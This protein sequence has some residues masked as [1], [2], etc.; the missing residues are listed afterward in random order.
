MIHILRINDFINESY[1][2]KD[3]Y[4]ELPKKVRK[5][6]KQPWDSEEVVKKAKEEYKEYVKTAQKIN[7]DNLEILVAK[8]KEAITNAKGNKAFKLR[9]EDCKFAS[10]YFKDGEYDFFDDVDTAV[11]MVRLSLEP[12][13][14]SSK[15]FKR[16]R[17]N[18]FNNEYPKLGSW[19]EKSAYA[20]N[21]YSYL[22]TIADAYNVDMPRFDEDL[23]LL[24]TKSVEHRIDDWNQ[25]RYSRP[26]RK[27][28]DEAYLKMVKKLEAGYE[29][30]AAKVKKAR[31]EFRKTQL[32]KDL[33]EI[34]DIVESDLKA[35]DNNYVL[36]LDIMK[37]RS[38]KNDYDKQVL[39]AM[40]I[41]K[42]YVQTEID[43]E[44]GGSKAYGGTNLLKLAAVAYV[45][46]DGMPTVNVKSSRT[47]SWL[48]GMHHY[49]TFEVI[50]KSG[51][52]FGEI[53]M[54][55]RGLDG[56]DGRPVDG[57]GPLD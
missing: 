31:E 20:I 25:D 29:K 15:D 42:D 38:K 4:F 44:F 30:D 12:E 57:F 6:S 17:K 49:V 24:S 53:E 28:S 26:H 23:N 36:W 32:Y 18:D 47:G 51:K 55:D 40:D 11:K 5:Y 3:N 41:V 52:S 9:A 56:D 43:K 35:A 19:S 54:E 50:G 1:T 21:L 27:M 33:N 10:I 48:A 14:M 34:L 2:S 46:D 8:L 13:D 22:Q 37:E 45:E 16:T 39:N 7:G